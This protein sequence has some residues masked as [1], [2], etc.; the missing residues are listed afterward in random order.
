MHLVLGEYSLSPASSW[1]LKMTRRPGERVEKSILSSWLHWISISELKRCGSKWDSNW[2]SC[3]NTLYLYWSY[4]AKP[5]LM[6]V[7][8]ISTKVWTTLMVVN[9]GTESKAKYLSCLYEAT[10]NW[11]HIFNRV[12][13]EELIANMMFV[14]YWKLSLLS[15][16]QF[17]VRWGVA[18]SVLKVKKLG[19]SFKMSIKFLDCTMSKTRTLI[20]YS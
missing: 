3:L 9:V 15:K 2:K 16:Q 6:R 19:I 18:L 14:I 8:T 20:F 11:E 13:Q 7:T 1:L 4:L 10:G 12:V 17:Q 5:S